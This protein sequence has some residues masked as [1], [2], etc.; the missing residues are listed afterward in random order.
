MFEQ[1]ASIAV[2]VLVWGIVM[3]ILLDFGPFERKKKGN[4]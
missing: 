3:L 4:E 1:V 2:G